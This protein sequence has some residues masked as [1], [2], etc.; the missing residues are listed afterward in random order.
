MC[1]CVYIYVCV[2][3]CVVWCVCVY[4]CVVWCVCMC[5][6]GW[7]VCVCVC[8]GGVYGKCGVVCVYVCV[9]IYIYI[10]ITPNAQVLQYTAVSSR[11]FSVTYFETFRVQISNTDR[12]F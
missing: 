3:M 12:L 8:V 5:V 11:R 6:C 10:R 4:V 2:C 9:Y 7:V 1:L